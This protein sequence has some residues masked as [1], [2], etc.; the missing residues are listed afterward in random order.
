MKYTPKNS[1]GL[2]LIDS[3]GN[4]IP[5]VYEFDDQS[6]EVKFYLAS[7]NGKVVV[8]G[9]SFSKGKTLVKASAIIYG[10]RMVHA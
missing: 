6:Y 3:N 9:D 7:K 2:K 5:F 8:S 1:K 4:T 10:A